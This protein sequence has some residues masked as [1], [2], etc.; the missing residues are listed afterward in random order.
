MAELTEAK[1]WEC[2]DCEEVIRHRVKATEQSDLPGE[3]G[4]K[5]IHECT[6]CSS[7]LETIEISKE[8]MVTL[9][10]ELTELRSFRETIVKTVN[11]LPA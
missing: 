4:Y 8:R 10:K 2:P 1:F 6:E 5:R 7:S 3:Q 9:L 11:D